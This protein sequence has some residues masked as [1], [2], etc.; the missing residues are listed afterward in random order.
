MQRAIDRAYLINTYGDVWKHA[1]LKAQQYSD[2]EFLAAYPREGGIFLDAVRE[3]AGPIIDRIAADIRPVFE[4]AV[5]DAVQNFQRIDVQL[6]QRTEYVAQ[7]GQD[8]ATFD[9]VAAHP[10]RS[11]GR[12]TQTDQSLKRLISSSPW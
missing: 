12:P 4:A 7:V 10:P 6:R 1:R 9:Q 3:G 2:T 5:G 11:G 8:I